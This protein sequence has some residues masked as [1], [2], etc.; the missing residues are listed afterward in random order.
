M[1]LMNPKNRIFA[2]QKFLTTLLFLFACLITYTQSIDEWYANAQQRIDTLRKGTFGL[3]VIDKNGQPFTGDISVRMTKHE[4][5]FGIAFDLYE[6]EANY[7]NAYSTTSTVNAEADAEIYQTERY[8]SYLAY[9]IPVEKDR[10]YILT[11]KFAEIYFNTAGSRIFDVFVE[12]ARYMSDFDM[13]AA[14]GGKNIAVDSSFTIHAADSIINIELV[15]SID[16]AAP[17]GIEIKTVEEDWITRINCGGAA[18]TTADGHYYESDVDYFD[19]NASRFPSEE[20]WM[21]AAMQK[22]FSYGVSGNSFKW[23]GIQPQHTAP[24]YTA[25]DNAVNWTQSI[26]WD[27]RAHTL[28]WGGYNYEDDHALP[29]WVKDLPTPQAITDTCKM[30]VIREVTRYRGI[31]KE[32]DVINEPLHATYLQS[33]VGDS[34]NWNCFKWARSADPDAELFINDYN[35]EYYWGD[36]AKYRDLIVK[37]K[38][39]G[40]PVTGVGMQAHFWE[41]MRPN[42]T[43]LVTQVNIVAEAGLPIKFTE[44]DNGILSQEDQASD[45]IKVMT[46]AFSHPSINGVVCWGLSDRGAWRE[47]SGLFDANHKPKLAADTLY[48]LTHKRWATNFDTTATGNDTVSFNAYYGNYTVEVNFDDTVKVF[49]IPLLK[50]YKDSV[51]VL[52]ENDALTKG[53]VLLVTQL[54]SDS[55]LSLIFDKSINAESIRSSDFKFFSDHLLRIQN[56][57]IDDEDSTTLNFTL[58]GVVTPDDFLCISYFPGTLA[59]TDGGKAFAFGPETVKNLTTGLISASVTNDGCNIEAVFNAKIQNLLENQESFTLTDNDQ[60]LEFDDI[61]YKDTDSSIAVFQFNTPL[62]SN[63]KP[64]LQ[65]TR[66][67]LMPSTGFQCQSSPVIIVS[68]VWPNL[69][70]ANVNTAGTRIFALFNTKLVNVPDNMNAFSISVDGEPFEVSNISETGT[71]STQITF[72]L[73]SK[74]PSGKTVTLSYQPGT[75]KGS[76]GNTMKP[77]ENAE[78]TNNSTAVGLNVQLTEG[79]LIYPNPARESVQ[80][81]WDTHLTSIVIRNLEGK[82]MVDKS[83]ISPVKSV[84]LPLRLEPGIYILQIQNETEI[85]N[86]KLVIE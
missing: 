29:R 82:T 6:G 83:F 13:F 4:Y 84:S 77:I 60:P 18:L 34:I 66:G 45:F 17:K 35:V 9:A 55:T 3:K 57:Q 33:V 58:Q 65:Y 38:S 75:I 70:R 12:G 26:G 32:Y 11:L 8:Y 59:S 20:Q 80:I 56:M 23:S 37:I 44:F 50:A 24:N 61:Q 22:Y 27:L 47:K 36:A 5:P 28:L 48:Y 73:P 81:S 40:G 19:Q 71:D 30:R 51:F 52:D 78:V 21:K 25:F 46:V 79:L 64:T 14:A 10:N 63:S 7:G 49:S 69:V 85:I 74:I 42:I 1:K 15:A 43:E 86:T 67:T 41:G 54:L 2:R 76:N 62:T 72:V 68:N 31:V 16:N 39:M 53:P